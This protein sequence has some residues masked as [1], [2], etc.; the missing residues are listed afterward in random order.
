VPSFLILSYNLYSAVRCMN[1]ISAAFRRLIITLFQFQVF[2]AIYEGESNENL[3]YFFTC[4]LL[5]KS[6]T[7]VYHFST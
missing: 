3:K 5:N 4:D 1:F 6:G 7:Q 2:T